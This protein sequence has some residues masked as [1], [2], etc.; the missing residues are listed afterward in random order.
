[1][2]WVNY[3]SGYTINSHDYYYHCRFVKVI[4]KLIFRTEKVTETQ[5]ELNRICLLLI[6]VSI[7]DGQ[8][9]LLWV[10]L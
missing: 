6:N 4:A 9:E 5:S 10:A 2:N 8:A 3:R 1:M 7:R